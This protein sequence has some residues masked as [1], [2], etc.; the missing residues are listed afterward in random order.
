MGYK[1]STV[2]EY[3]M[4]N[5]LSIFETFK[6]SF[7][8]Q[9]RVFFLF[10]SIDAYLDHQNKHVGNVIK[11][12]SDNVVNQNDAN[13]KRVETKKLFKCDHCPKTFMS[14]SSLQAHVRVHTGI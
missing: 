12:H 13:V 8:N 6:I 9:I 4:K 5:L 11:E 14:K 1:K 2:A 7:H 10:F 3:V